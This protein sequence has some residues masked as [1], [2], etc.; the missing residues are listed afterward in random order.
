[1]C[2]TDVGGGHAHRLARVSTE[3]QNLDLQHDALTKAGTE[4][5]WEDKASGA[6]DDRLGLADALSH[7]RK[8]DCLVVW[9]LDR[10][11]RSMRALIELTEGLRERGVEFRSLTEGI[12]TTTP[13]GRFYFH[14]LGALAQMERELNR[15][16]AV[17]GLSAARA[18]GRKGGRRPKLSPKQIEHARKLLGDRT[19]TIKDVAASLGVNRATIYRALG[20][21]AWGKSEAKR[22]V[23]CEGGT[24]HKPGLNAHVTRLLP[25]STANNSM[26]EEHKRVVRRYALA[27]KACRNADRTGLTDLEQDMAQGYGM[28]LCGILL[29]PQAS[30]VITADAKDPKFFAAIFGNDDSATPDMTAYELQQVRRY[31]IRGEGTVLASKRRV[32]AR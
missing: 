3:D 21:G 32:V 15:E 12:D 19:V 20:L 30:P 24:G 27:W 11:G 4:R 13:A 7:A 1:L 25:P 14:I 5:I 29:E 17:A 18:R 22:R 23:V 31:I 9:R 28:L 6:R 2:N 16:R 26:D 10:L 8:G